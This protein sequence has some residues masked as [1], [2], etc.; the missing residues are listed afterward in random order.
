MILIYASLF[1]ICLTCLYIYV[2]YDFSFSEETKKSFSHLFWVT[3]NG[4]FVNS[5]DIKYKSNKA[6]RV[7]IKYSDIVEF[8]FKKKYDSIIFIVILPNKHDGIE[9]P[10]FE[11]SNEQ[12]YD[13][14]EELKTKN[15]ISIN[16]FTRLIK[17]ESRFEDRVIL[18][19]LLSPNA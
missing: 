5:S 6:Y 4:L 9:F 2:Y 14:L 19:Q 10:S 7:L 16:D 18:P 17:V 12:Y 13:L 3:N 1:S 8:V 11:L 15:I